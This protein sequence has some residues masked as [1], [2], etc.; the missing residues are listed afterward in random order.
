MGRVKR[1]SSRLV[2]S[3]EGRAVRMSHTRDGVVPVLL[4]HR[5]VMTCLPS[6]AIW[7]TCSSFGSVAIS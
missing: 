1:T 3:D 6:A 2:G 4:L 5:F 7:S